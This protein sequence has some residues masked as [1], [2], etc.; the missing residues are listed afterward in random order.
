MKVFAEAFFKKLEGAAGPKPR[1]NCREP[2]GGGLAELL[3]E[4]PVEAAQ[5]NEGFLAEPFFQKRRE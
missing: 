2:P 4:P 3:G 5:P 1:G